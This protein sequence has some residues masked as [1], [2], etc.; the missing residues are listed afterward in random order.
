[1]VFNLLSPLANAETETKLIDLGQWVAYGHVSDAGC[2]GSYRVTPLLSSITLQF[3]YKFD[4][5]LTDPTTFGQYMGSYALLNI[6]CPFS[7]DIVKKEQTVNVS[8]SIGA[9]SG[10]YVGEV[11]GGGAVIAGGVSVPA[12]VD[13]ADEEYIFESLANE[14]LSSIDQN[15]LVFWKAE[16]SDCDFIPLTSTDA[17]WS[18]IG[19]VK[20][21]LYVYQHCRK[22]DYTLYY[23]E[24]D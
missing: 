18:I 16:A 19:I 23:I 24:K 4:F 3:N 12:T 21:T 14:Q 11:P 2:K 1:M 17:L 13:N 7:F 9:T 10:T 8:R 6:E 20:P 15:N 22:I 5:R